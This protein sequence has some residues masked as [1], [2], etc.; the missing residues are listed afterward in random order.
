MKPSK[1]RI[2]WYWTHRPALGGGTELVSQAAI[3]TYVSTTDEGRVDLTG[4]PP[5]EAPCN[6]EGVLYSAEPK[7]GCW[8]WPPRVEP[9][10]P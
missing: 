9:G 8:S 3:V 7:Y 6:Y 1:G 5:N 2:V 10:P 4:F